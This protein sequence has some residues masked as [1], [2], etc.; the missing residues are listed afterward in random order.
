MAEQCKSHITMDSLKSNENNRKNA[1]MLGYLE[2]VFNIDNIRNTDE[3]HVFFLL[4]PLC[5]QHFI[6]TAG[7]GAIREKEHIFFTLQ[8]SFKVSMRVQLQEALITQVKHLLASDPAAGAYS[9]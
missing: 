8:K 4:S 5:I 6:F 7:K 9:E 1:Q 3:K 2:S